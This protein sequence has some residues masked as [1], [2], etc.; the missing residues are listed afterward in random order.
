MA[1][2]VTAY[3]LL[4][5][6][7][8]DVT[9][10]IPKI[11]RSV[12]LCNNLYGRY[13]NIIVRML[14]WSTNVSPDMRDL[15]QRVIN[16]EIVDSADMVVG[17]FGNRFGTPTK[18]YGSG[19]EEE[20]ER[21]IANDKKVF[22]YFLNVPVLPKDISF[23]QYNKVQE[24][25]E[26]HEGLY[27]ESDVDEF[28]KKFFGHLS[29]H[30]NKIAAHDSPSSEGSSRSKVLWVD[31]RPEFTVYERRELEHYGLDFTLSLSTRQALS[32][33]R[34]DKFSL[35]ISDMNR[36]EGPEEGYKLLNEVRKSDQKIPFIIYTGHTAA[37]DVAKVTN[38][39]GQGYTS[40]PM[41]LVDLVLVNLLK[42]Q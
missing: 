41:K 25:K 19:T 10:H 18:E 20:I 4:I 37:E 30:I 40:D 13:N 11:E 24:F 23:E 33:L 12:S 17:I 14:H 38:C 31:D 28:E 2:I 39:G 1:Q 34:K 7:P 26:R 16:K 36:K 5:S 15:A 42:S 6:C 27:C 29:L 22:L 9:E 21:M 35:I 32:E 3:D 8:S